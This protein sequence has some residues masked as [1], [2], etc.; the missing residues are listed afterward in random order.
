[1]LIWSRRL[2]SCTI[3]IS[4]QYVAWH[5]LKHSIYLHFYL[6]SQ[7]WPSA[8]KHEEPASN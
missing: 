2:Q 6:I 1:M 3:Q 5:K 4:M 8:T 7:N